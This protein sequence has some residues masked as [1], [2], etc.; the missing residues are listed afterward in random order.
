MPLEHWLAGAILVSLIAYV[1]GAGADF[2][3]GV[4]DLLAFGPRAREQRTLIAHAIGPIW[5]ANHVWLILA[6]VLLFVCFPAGFAA[7]S[8]ALHVPL[9][10]MLVGIVLR[11]SAFTF[12]SYG[13]V[14]D[15]TQERWGR[16]FAIASL[17][18]PITLGA[19]VGA[20]ASG[21]IRLRDGHVAVGFFESWLALFPAVIGLLAVTLFAFLAAVYLTMETEDAALR[22]DFRRR[23]LAAGLV[24]GALAFAALAMTRT[25]APLL[26]AG[27]VTRGSSLAFH[28]ATGTCAVGALAALWRRRFAPARALAIAQAA[29]ILWGWGWA[30]FPYLIP[31]DLTFAAGAAPPAVLSVVLVA[32][33]LGGALLVPSLV[34]LFRVF[35]AARH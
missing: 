23:A 31:P 11:G 8:T 4:W 12:R 2:G 1:L 25:A 16:V 3:G 29:L 10:V 9:T 13:R 28:A 7:I 22:D 34:Y 15:A 19:C 6:V 27:L 20:I 35:K 21:A 17:L 14:S 30:Q 33:L 32:L 26:Y 5:E 24:L 18:T